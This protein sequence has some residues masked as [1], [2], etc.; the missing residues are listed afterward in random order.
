MPRRK[1]CRKFG[2]GAPVD[3][4]HGLFMAQKGLRTR[5]LRPSRSVPKAASSPRRRPEADRQPVVH[6]VVTS[7]PAMLDTIKGLASIVRNFPPS[8]RVVVWLNEYFGP[9]VN[10]SGRPFEELPAC[11]DNKERIFAVIRARHRYRWRPRRRGR[12]HRLSSIRSPSATASRSLRPASGQGLS[13]P[14]FGRSPDQRPLI[15]D[16]RDRS[17][18]L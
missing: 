18:T 13:P 1:I 6:V 9:I 10:A 7:G 2:F 15:G 5:D 3:H 16:E 11:I 4:L 8:V 17:S 14:V 12:C